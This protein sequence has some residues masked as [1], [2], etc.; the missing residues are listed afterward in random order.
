MFL[1]FPVSYR[2]SNR[3]HPKILNLLRPLA[4]VN[5]NR[6]VKSMWNYYGLASRYNSNRHSQPI[7]V[8][9]VNVNLS[10]I[11]SKVLRTILWLL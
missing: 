8:K 11:S 2:G 10:V 9:L 3:E 4:N 1:L 6:V 5:G 7:S